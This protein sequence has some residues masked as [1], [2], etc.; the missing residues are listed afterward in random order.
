LIY[1]YGNAPQWLMDII[2]ELG[3]RMV[4]IDDCASQHRAI[5]IDVHGDCHARGSIMLA[6]IPRRGSITIDR[7][8]VRG[9]LKSLTTLLSTINGAKTFED[10]L[11]ML[12][13]VRAFVNDYLGFSEIT[14]GN[15]RV[16][17]GGVYSI[18]APGQGTTYRVTLGRGSARGTLVIDA[19]LGWLLEFSRDIYVA[20]GD[21]VLELIALSMIFSVSIE[22]PNPPY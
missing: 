3:Y 19:S 10:S 20:R 2:N 15:V 21:L 12:G 7:H 11:S 5:I 17:V 6:L 18:V 22:L 14:T 4:E 8:N 1:V 13:F 16:E 9:I